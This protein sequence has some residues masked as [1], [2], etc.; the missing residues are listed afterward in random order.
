VLGSPKTV[1]PIISP[2]CTLYLALPFKSFQPVRSLPLNK[3]FQ[4]VWAEIKR[5]IKRKKKIEN[6]FFIW[7]ISAIQIS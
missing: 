7:L 2:F 3:F 1:V 4:G 6:N 5:V